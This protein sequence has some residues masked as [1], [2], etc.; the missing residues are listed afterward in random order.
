VPQP[1][2]LRIA[3]DLEEQIRSGSLSE[4]SQLPTETELKEQYG[5][6]RNTVRD[7]V[8]RL[9]G[10]GLIETRPGKG[11]F[12]TKRP[13]PFVT[14][15]TGAP[16]SAESGDGGAIYLSKV[17]AEHRRPLETMPKVELQYAP[18]EVA[19]RLRVGPGTQFVSRYQERYIDD[20]PWSLQTTWYPMKF[21]ERGATRLLD[22]KDITEGAVKYLGEA[23]GLNQVGWRDWI[24]ARSPDS[25]EQK[26]F[27]IAH[28][29]AVF[30]IF[31]TGFDQYRK[32]MRVTVTVF[33]TDRNQFI[34]NVGDVPGPQYDENDENEL[35]L[36]NDNALGGASRIRL[37]SLRKAA[38]IAG[39]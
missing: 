22:S 8:Q 13:D 18:E 11:T 24:T 37:G 14:V 15:L 2:Y 4:G 39:T 10:K 38:I 1:L 33:P 30:E 36:E 28:D 16:E 32:P 35:S 17:R 27:G 7:A 12:V 19:R 21:V 6:S 9:T 26:F 5:A 23:I 34:V 3:E 20:L 29:A 31:R 25:N